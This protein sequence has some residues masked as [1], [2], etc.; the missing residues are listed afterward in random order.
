LHRQAHSDRILCLGCFGEQQ[1]RGETV[2]Q[3]RVT[4]R[5]AVDT[6]ADIA[7]RL[8]ALVAELKTYKKPA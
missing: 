4:L 5:A 1:D 2:L 7:E 3:T 6:G 8:V